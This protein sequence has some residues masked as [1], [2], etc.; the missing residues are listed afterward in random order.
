MSD[1]CNSIQTEIENANDRESPETSNMIEYTTVTGYFFQDEPGTDP[2]IFNHVLCPL[3]TGIHFEALNQRQSKT[4]FGLIDRDY[5]TDTAFD[6]NRIKTQWERFV[7][8][9]AYL[10]EQSN[11]DVEYKLLYMG[12]HG[13]GFHNIAEALYGTPAWD[14]SCKLGKHDGQLSL[15]LNDSRI[16]PCNPEMQI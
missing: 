15:I 13:Q 6:P 12:R 7:H 3:W 16:G 14:V 5:E 10:N 11:G 2:A 9:L 1:S 8:H 4:N